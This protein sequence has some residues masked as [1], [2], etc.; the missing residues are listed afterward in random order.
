[1]YKTPPPDD[2]QQEYPQVSYAAQKRKR[3]AEPKQ[4][5]LPL[6]YYP[7][8]LPQIPRIKRASLHLNQALQQDTGTRSP[9]TEPSRLRRDTQ[10]NISSARKSASSPGT[11]KMKPAPFSNPTTE[12]SDEYGYLHRRVTQNTP[13][14]MATPTKQ[15]PPLYESSRP[16]H[17]LRH[18]RDRHNYTQLPLLARLQYLRYNPAVVLIASLSLVV[19]LLIPVIVAA[20]HSHTSVTSIATSSANTQPPA[21]VQQAPLNPHELIIIPQDTDHPPPPVFATSAYLLDADT[22]TT[23]YAYNPFLHLPM[24]STTKLMTAALAVEHGN[25]DAQITITSAMNHDISQLSPDS[26][27]FGIKQGE[28]YTLRDLLYGLLFVSGNDAAVAIADAIGGNLPNFVAEMNQKAHQLGLY[29]T[30]FMNPHGL[31]QTGQF[32]SAHDLALLGKYS[33]GLPEIH[34]I[35]GQKYYHIPAGGNHPERIIL[36]ENQFLWWYP[37]VDAGKT[38]WDAASDFIQVISVTRNNHHLIGVVMHTNDWWTDMRDLMNWGFDSFSWVSP[39]DLD[40]PQHPIPYDYLWNYFAKDT[41]NVTI[42]TAD[43]GRYYIYTGFSVSGPILKYFDSKQ[44][45]KTF[46]YPTSLQTAPDPSV[47]SQQFQHGTISCNLQTKS[48]QTV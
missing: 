13:R 41:R 11:K 17:R 16:P 25:L 2:E 6:D 29:D 10:L 36:N 33:L 28:T 48:C 12:F 7:D 31:L 1:M 44:G 24:L 39:H 15:P 14:K 9:G 43:S 4:P 47:L 32:S 35:S 37:G 19:L 8:E 34:Q 45:L 46:G 38:G 23:L 5:S 27:M 30:H 18:S 22:G 21:R 3:A 20:T 42:P 40:S 26:S